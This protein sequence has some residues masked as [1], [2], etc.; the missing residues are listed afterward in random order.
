MFAVNTLFTFDEKSQ[1]PRPMCSAK[2]VVNME[3]YAEIRE[4]RQSQVV[5]DALNAYASPA[6]AVEETEE[7]AQSGMEAGEGEGF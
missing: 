1:Y 2:S 7:Q 4:Y 5:I 6:D 3:E